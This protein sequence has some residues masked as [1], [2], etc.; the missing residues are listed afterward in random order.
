MTNMESKIKDRE[1]KK[2]ELLSLISGKIT[3]KQMPGAFVGADF[4]R[5]P[6]WVARIDKT[7]VFQKTKHSHQVHPFYFSRDDALE[8]ALAF[9][10]EL[11]EMLN[12]TTSALAEP[13]KEEGNPKALPLGSPQSLFPLAHPH[14]PCGRDDAHPLFKSRGRL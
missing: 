1:W 10:A 2:G 4:I 9:K 14:S 6:L 7:D 13:Q 8:G 12:K 11:Q 5:G 3:V